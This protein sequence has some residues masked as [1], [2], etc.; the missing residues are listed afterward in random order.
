MSKS[1]KQ[2]LNKLRVLKLFFDEVC[3]MQ[4]ET[5]THISKDFL[6]PGPNMTDFTVYLYLFVLFFQFS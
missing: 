1:L 5:A 4:S 6:T 3:S 2:S